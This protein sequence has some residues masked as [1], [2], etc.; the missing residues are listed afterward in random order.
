MVKKNWVVF[1]K[2]ILLFC[3]ELIGLV[4]EVKM[5]KNLNGILNMKLVIIMVW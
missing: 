4:V 1:I 5:V 3:L 2:Y